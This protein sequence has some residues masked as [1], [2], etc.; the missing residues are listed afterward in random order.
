MGIRAGKIK[1]HLSVAH[2]QLTA[3]NRRA[4]GTVMA[5]CG[6]TVEN[7]RRPAA[8]Q[9]PGRR[10]RIVQRI[11]QP[12]DKRLETVAGQHALDALLPQ[13]QGGQ[14]GVQ[15]ALGLV[16][17]PAVEQNGLMD[18]SVQP[19]K[20]GKFDRN[21]THAFGP[22][23][24]GRWIIAAHNLPA[25]IRHM[26]PDEE[27]A[28]Q[29]LGGVDRRKN[30]Q[31][32]GLRPTPIRIVGHHQIAGPQIELIIIENGLRGERQGGGVKRVLGNN[33]LT[34]RSGEGHRVVAGFTHRL[35]RTVMLQGDAH[36]IHNRP[37]IMTQDF[38]FDG[39]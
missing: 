14:H 7:A 10:F 16:R 15:Q 38:A 26:H 24:Q 12:F 1:R 31:I 4:L 19:A 21:N 32:L 33:H 39:T 5:E 13:R 35:G 22:Y 11:F 2:F 20:A 9:R 3:D 18:V 27:A 25:E 29:F 6:L 8:D 28:D 30:R 17:H 37:Q 23:F 34:A 36:I